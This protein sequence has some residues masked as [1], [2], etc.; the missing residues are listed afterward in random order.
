MPAEIENVS[1]TPAMMR[2]A[3]SAWTE[4]PQSIAA[5]SRIIRYP[6]STSAGATAGEMKV[7][8]TYGTCWP[9]SAISGTNGTASRNSPAVTSDARPVRAPSDTPAPDSTYVVT[10]DVPIAPPS[11]AAAE[12]TSSSRRRPG[13]PP[14]RAT[15]PPPATE[16]PP[17]RPDRHRGADGVEEVGHEQREYRRH[18]RER[19]RI[20]Q[21]RR[22]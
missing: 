20:L 8:S 17:R 9:A 13:R 18:E 4:S 16:E 14:T 6:T 21:V 11:A 1:G 7:L 2:N 15:G 12:S 22:L 19:Q 3:G 10:D 5:T